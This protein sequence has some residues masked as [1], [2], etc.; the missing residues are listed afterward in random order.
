MKEELKITLSKG[1]ICSTKHQRACAL[2]LGLKK[3]GQTVIRKNDPCIR[4]M[5]KK[6]IHLLEIEEI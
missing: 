4:G 1:L 5:A 6:I 3:R 2:G